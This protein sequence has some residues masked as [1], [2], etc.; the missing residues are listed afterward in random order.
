MTPAPTEELEMSTLHCSTER[1][2][3]HHDPINTSFP[4]SFVCLTHKKS[5]VRSV[6]SGATPLVMSIVLFDPQYSPFHCRDLLL[7][8]VVA[9]RQ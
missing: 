3:Q 1:L 7:F 5:V 4:Y 6:S 8:M 9:T 2:S